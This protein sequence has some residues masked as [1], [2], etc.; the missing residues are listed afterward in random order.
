MYKLFTHYVRTLSTPKPIFLPIVSYLLGA[1]WVDKEEVGHY[2]IVILEGLWDN[3]QKLSS[4][5]FIG[6]DKLFLTSL[7]VCG[8]VCFSLWPLQLFS[9]PVPLGFWLAF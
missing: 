6:L 5:R 9:T 2:N 7:L 8:P 4:I 3:T 1:H